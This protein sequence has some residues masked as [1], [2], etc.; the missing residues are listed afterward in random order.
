MR[1]Y[2]GVLTAACAWHTAWWRYKADTATAISYFAALW[3]QVI[4]KLAAKRIFTCA[5]AVEP[6]VK[7]EV[8][9]TKVVA[10]SCS[11]A[12]GGAAT[13]HLALPCSLMLQR[14]R[15]RLL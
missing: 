1:Q 14:G 7:R 5:F 4:L 15:R 10:S 12:P 2:C 9:A 6:A 8:A 13:C 11:S 3:C